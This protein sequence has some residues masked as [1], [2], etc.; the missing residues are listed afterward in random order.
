VADQIRPGT[1][2]TASGG[3]ASDRQLQTW[4]TRPLAQWPPDVFD[5]LGVKNPNEPSNLSIVLDAITATRGVPGDVVEC[6][7][8]RGSSLGTLGLFLKELGVPKR[9]WG[10]DSFQ[11]FPPAGPHDLIGGVLPAKSQ[12]AYFADTH[13]ELVRRLA[14]RLG[15][16]GL[17]EI[18]AGY[19]EDTCP[20]LPVQAI[21]VLW[22]DC[23]LYGS[24]TTCLQHL[25]PR[26]SPGG[27]IVFDE[28]YSKKYP[29]AR[30]AVDEFFADK[31]E[32]PRLA[33]EYLRYSEYER[34]YVVKR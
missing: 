1:S 23:D 2:G 9:L 27:W 10:L 6:G 12:P 32:K 11:G 13:E 34:W 33:R 5:E 31:A 7:V 26:V 16:D 4:L 19:F 20:S 22:L 15:V 30:V 28:Y 3:G 14:R 18:V 17:V 29:G 25:Y 21:S 24:Y 8:Y